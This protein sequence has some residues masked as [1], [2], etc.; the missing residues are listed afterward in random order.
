MADTNQ[1][2]NQWQTSDETT[3]Q[4]QAKNLAST[5][6][7]G[8]QTSAQN[9]Q[10]A[11]TAQQEATTQTANAI[12]NQT[13]QVAEGNNVNPLTIGYGT[14]NQSSNPGIGALTIQQPATPAAGQYATAPTTQVADTSG[15]TQALQNTT[16]NPN[17][18]AFTGQSGNIDAVYSNSI[19]P[20]TNQTNLASQFQQFLSA[21]GTNTNATDQQFQTFLQNQLSQQTATIQQQQQSG[22]LNIQQA[23]AAQQAAVQ[24]Y[25]LNLNNGLTGLQT[26]T[27]DLT[28]IGNQS[29]AEQQAASINGILGNSTSGTQALTALTGGNIPQNLAALSQQAQ[30]GA[31]NQAQGQAKINS[32]EAENASTELGN[33]KQNEANA[34]TTAN[35]AIGTTNSNMN[36]SLSQNAT[37]AQQQLATAYN[38]AST[39]LTSQEQ[40]AVNNAGQLLQKANIAPQQIADAAQAW[41][42]VVSNYAAQATSPQDL[43]NLLTQYEAVWRM[44]V[45]GQDIGFSNQIASIFQPTVTAIQNQLNQAGGGDGSGQ[46]VSQTLAND[47]TMGLVPASILPGVSGLWSS[48]ATS[49][50]GNTAHSFGL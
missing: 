30:A 13:S 7:Q 41:T 5:G 46:S 16:F 2:Q 12:G 22:S 4:N 34:F 11:T 26:S 50:I 44:A 29:A 24:Q 35:T 3:F 31:L 36:M 14:N 28:N 18:A 25:I 27:A 17:T 8:L 20:N 49:G 15:S 6:A 33:A 9:A 37:A 23:Q 39:N 48:S 42:N 1:S 40:Q 10:Q 45:Q 19:L 43:S 21:Q 32:Q 47:A 38:T